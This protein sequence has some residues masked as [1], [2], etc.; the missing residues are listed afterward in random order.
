MCNHLPAYKQFNFWNTD[1]VM[2]NITYQ[3][4]KMTKKMTEKKWQKN[5]KKKKKKNQ[6]APEM[7][8][9]VSM[10]VTALTECLDNVTAIYVAY[11]W[12]NDGHI[13]QYSKHKNIVNAL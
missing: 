4:K 1:T 9:F 2:H 5:E 7:R 13:V 12:F 3:K 10:T 11:S 8:V 6:G